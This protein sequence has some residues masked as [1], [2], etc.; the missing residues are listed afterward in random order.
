MF[1]TRTRQVVGLDI[2]S[3]A[4]K[5][6]VLRQAKGDLP[7][8]LAHFG[9]AELPD[10]SIVDGAVA[11][12]GAV[13]QSVSALLDQHKVKGRQ[14]ATSVSGNA[15]IVRRVSMTRRDP[16]ELRESLPWEAEEYIP[17]DIEEVDLDFAILEENEE[18]DTMEVVLVAAKRDRVDEYVDVVARS[19]RKTTVMDIDAFAVQNAFEFAYPER[20]FE[21]IAILNLGASLVNVAVLEG[22]KP[23]FWRDIAVG[24]RLYTQALQRHFMLD[25]LDAEDLLRQVSRVDAK[26]LAGGG[27]SGG[28]GLAEFAADGEGGAELQDAA[29]DPRVREVIGQVSDRVANEIKKTFDFYEAQSGREHFDAVFLAGGGAHI[30]DLA[31]RLEERLGWPVERMDPLRRVR[32]PEDAFDAEYVWENGPESAVA[33]GLALRGVTE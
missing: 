1:L 33:M 17:F 25:Y 4:V 20:Q 14:V 30:T 18:Q 21:D 6:V 22:G 19:S 3:H 29:A 12:P 28:R 23:A 26:R 27:E 2:G 16:E 24:M 10:E 13:A 5:M 8:E 7:F 9:V 32:I 11:V 31:R 15:V